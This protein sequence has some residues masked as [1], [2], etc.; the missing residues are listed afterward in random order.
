MI[1]EK[2]MLCKTYQCKDCSIQPKP[3]PSP[4]KVLCNHFIYLQT[5]EVE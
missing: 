3:P 2:D 4:G 1:W 5:F